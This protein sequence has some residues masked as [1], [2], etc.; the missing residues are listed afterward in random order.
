MSLG[1]G[2]AVVSAMFSPWNDDCKSDAVLL[3]VIFVPAN[4]RNNAIR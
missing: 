1:M 4:L 2:T 3:G